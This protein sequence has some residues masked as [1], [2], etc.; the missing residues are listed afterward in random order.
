MTSTRYYAVPGNAQC[1]IANIDVTT[2]HALPP[3]P[4]HQCNEH[5]HGPRDPYSGVAVAPRLASPKMP[6]L[7]ILTKG[8]RTSDNGSVP[9][10]WEACS[11]FL[12]IPQT[13]HEKF[14]TTRTI[15]REHLLRMFRV[16]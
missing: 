2:V 7:F 11:Y 5:T 3:V 4:A 8:K 12:G 15:H 14:L 16:E 9:E 1:V 10:S 6:L 13:S